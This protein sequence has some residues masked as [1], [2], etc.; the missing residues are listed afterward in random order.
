MGSADFEAALEDSLRGR[1]EKGQSQ[2]RRLI[3]RV[4]QRPLKA[5]SVIIEEGYIDRD[6]LDEH[7]AFYSRAFKPYGPR[8]NRLHFFRAALDSD[9]IALERL[10]ASYVGFAVIRPGDLPPLGRTV[11]QPYRR[12]PNRHFFPCVAMF[13]SSLQGVT[14]EVEG[15]PFLQQEA[16]VGRCAQAALWMTARYMSRRFRHREF[17]PSEV[18]A[19]AKRHMALGRTLPAEWGLCPA[20]VL[21]A[22]EGMG[23]SAIHYE[24]KLMDE[25]SRFLEGAYLA[26]NPPQDAADRV[27]LARQQD[28]KLAD[29]VYRYVESGLPVILQSA[30]HAVVAIGHSYEHRPK[31]AI[32]AAIQRIPSFFIHDEGVGP[33]EEMPILEYE[34]ALVRADSK[35]TF[36][37]SDVHTVFA[38]V[39]AGVTLRGES[40]EARARETVRGFIQSKVGAQRSKRKPSAH[41]RTMGDHLQRMH[42]EVAV[43]LSQL[44]YRT[45]LLPDHEWQARLREEMNDG[46]LGPVFGQALLMLDYPKYVWVT[47]ISSSPLLARPAR[48]QRLCLGRVIVDST[49]PSGTEATLATH[50]LDFLQLPAPDTAHPASPP[51]YEPGYAPFRHRVFS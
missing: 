43:D 11:L 2:L 20:Q 25:C 23:F 46:T 30:D 12:N 9:A 39:P 4:Q 32:R 18:N 37:F 40:A 51:H 41:G 16:Q 22:L 48:Q 15:M 45:Y 8:C 6:Y 26:N 7:G 28:A 29:I 13:Y 35:I 19:L 5:R 44:E 38:V 42:P 3:E 17:R 27:R 14:L 36:W 50:I 34:Y 21:D 49:A 33:Y 31:K 47:E 1:S 24:R 10:Q